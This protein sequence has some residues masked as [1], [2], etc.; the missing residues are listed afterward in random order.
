MDTKLTQQDPQHNGQTQ[1]NGQNLR[2]KHLELG[3][4]SEIYQ[5]VNQSQ[6]L[7]VLLLNFTQTF[8]ERGKAA[9]CRGHIEL[10]NQ[11][12]EIK[13]KEKVEEALRINNLF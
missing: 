12:Q 8:S 3:L 7:E 13:I 10:V 11:K 6:H 2:S 4:R 1:N 5:L 9:Y